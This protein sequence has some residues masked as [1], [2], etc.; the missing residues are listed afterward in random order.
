MR[1]NLDVLK[2]DVLMK[3][4]EVKKKQ[5][6]LQKKTIELGDLIVELLKELENETIQSW[7]S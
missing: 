3:Y 7:R 2:I 5:F 1:T 4:K 6:L